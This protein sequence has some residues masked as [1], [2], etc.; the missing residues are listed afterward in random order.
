MRVAHEAHFKGGRG[1]HVSGQY[2]CHT[3]AGRKRTDGHEQH[4][5]DDRH[6]DKGCVDLAV[7]LAER[8]HVKALVIAV[9]VSLH[10]AEQEAGER[11]EK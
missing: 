3:H 10:D 6:G 11:E 8:E 1:L 7:E 9:L 4:D 2:V 5:A